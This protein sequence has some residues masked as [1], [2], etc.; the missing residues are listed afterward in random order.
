MS[1]PV[2]K[3]ALLERKKK[4]EEEVK[5]KRSN[6][7]EAKLASL[8]AW[9]RAIALREKQ[10]KG[11][12]ASNL[13]ITKN[14]ISSDK[15]Q[16]AV[17]R[18][19]GSDSPILNQKSKSKDASSSPRPVLSS[20]TTKT[21]NKKQV[22]QK[23]KHSSS[24]SAAKLAITPIASFATASSAATPPSP[25]QED[26]DPS[27]AA[28]PA[29]K[30]ALI[31]KKRQQQ[32]KPVTTEDVNIVNKQNSGEDEPDSGAPTS[33]NGTLSA[34]K[35]QRPEVV[36]RRDAEEAPAHRLVEQ[37]GKT[38]H[39]PVY[40]EVDEWANVREQDDKFQGLP[41]WKQALIKR[42]RADIAKRSGLPVPEQSPPTSKADIAKLPVPEKSAPPTSKANTYS[43][44]SKKAALEQRNKTT[45]ISPRKVKTVNEQ[46]KKVGVRE[47][48]SNRKI[49]TKAVDLKLVSK[50]P[51]TAKSKDFKPARKAPLPPSVKDPMF[52]YNFSKST[53][54]TL[55]TGGTS[56]DSTDSEL[57]DAVVT[58]LDESSDEGDSG[59]V[60]QSYSANKP[61]GSSPSLGQK[62][63]SESS[64]S[65]EP[66]LGKKRKVSVPHCVPHPACTTTPCSCSCDEFHGV[67]HNLCWNTSTQS[68]TIRIIMRL[69]KV[70]VKTHLHPL[71]PRTLASPIDSTPH[72][73]P[74]MS[75][76]HMHTVSVLQHHLG[77]LPQTIP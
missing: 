21:D 3:L 20:A 34:P 41:L 59:I 61:S 25:S 7:E 39:A 57:E 56:S 68:M 62:S 38:L 73:A 37:E 42:R 51:V 69:S 55:D 6:A 10:A 75:L 28:L 71:P 31:L 47:L 36:N 1:L 9:K 5:I 22:M 76:I 4:Q 74:T 35:A 30:R 40:K 63:H 27:L 14:K 17:E 11:P 13:P 46:K 8:P 24:S 70:E 2:W 44:L 19:K 23:W 67:T 53:R 60:L 33:C 43:P 72:Y 12:T 66:V 50:E 32:Q 18:V 77:A 49:L 64:V 54:H 52:T 45:S 58:N 48:S 65:T 29:W 15:W 26:E 16:V